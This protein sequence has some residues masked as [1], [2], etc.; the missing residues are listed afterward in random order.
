MNIYG[1]SVCAEDF[2]VWT[3]WAEKEAKVSVYCE[4]LVPLLRE[5]EGEA[6]WI[7]YMMLDYAV[8]ELAEMKYIGELELLS[9]ACDEPALTLGELLPHFMDKLS[10][11]KE[12]LFDARRYCQLYSGYQMEPSEEADDGLRRDVFT[13]AS[14]FLSLLNEFLRAESRIMDAFYQN[15]IAAG[16]FCYPLYGFTGENRG[17]QILDFRDDT[18][19]MI[20]KLA[21]PD[22]FT[23]TGGATGIYYGYLDF[24]AWDLKAVLDAAVSVFAKSEMEW[25]M[26]HSFRQDADGITL[27]EKK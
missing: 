19:D 10:Y 9:A 20:E 11:S 16:Y 7:A 2:Q 6:Y 25:V 13:G 22:N 18:A 8:G 21:G 23:Y 17:A 15:G 26:L 3:T 5:K 27:Y 14:C 24:I 4:K 1:E 12:E